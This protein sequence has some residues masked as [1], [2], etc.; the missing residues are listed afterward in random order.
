MIYERR[1]ETYKERS[2]RSRSKNRVVI[3]RSTE[4][5]VRMSVFGSEI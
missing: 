4:D 5:E 1:E 2:K 3:E